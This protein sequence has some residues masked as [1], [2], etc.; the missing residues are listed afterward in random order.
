[1][2]SKPPYI[3]GLATTS[4]PRRSRFTRHGETRKLERFKIA[5]DELLEQLDAGMFV[6]LGG[7]ENDPWVVHRLFFSRD[8][9]GWGVAVQDKDTKHI[10]TV[11]PLE[12]YANLHRKV[13]PRERGVAKRLVHWSPSRQCV[14]WTL[15]D[16]TINNEK[17]LLAA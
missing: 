13:T 3:V 1:M 8:D 4:L 7:E 6:H 5:L 15:L 12:Y 2:K 9:G 14:D 16:T 10:L 17:Y 11:L